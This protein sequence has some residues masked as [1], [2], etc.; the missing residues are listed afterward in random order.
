MPVGRE[1][2]AR[3]DLLQ[4]KSPEVF[5]KKVVL[6]NFCKIHRKTLSLGSRSDG[7]IEVRLATLFKKRLQHRCFSVDFA[8]LLRTLFPIAPL[9]NCIWH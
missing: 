5:H 6:K 7:G 8:K 4:K 9:G 1:R 2:W 3:Q